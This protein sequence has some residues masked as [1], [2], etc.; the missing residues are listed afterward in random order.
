[1]SKDIYVQFKGRYTIDGESLDKE[2]AKWLEVTSWSHDIRQ[3]KSATASTAGG[4]TSERAEHA[5][6]IFTKDLDLTSPKLWE[7]ASAGYTFDE[8]TIDFMR[9][10]GGSRVKYLTIKLK[11]ALI[12]RVTPSVHSEGL[13]TESFALTYA[14]I[15]WEYQQQ[16]VEGG[17]VSGRNVTAWS[18]SK[19]T[20]TY[21][22]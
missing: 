14:A 19:N 1:M 22:I 8:V 6:L 16:K 7:A 4:H 15:Q 20:N 2:H 3:P 11:H 21:A 12:S 18:L 13:P 5:D 9:A 10:D 17:G